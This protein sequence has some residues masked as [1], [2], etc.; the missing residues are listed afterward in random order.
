MILQE[1]IQTEANI[2]SRVRVT[3]SGY[4]I[5]RDRWEIAYNIE[6]IALISGTILSS[7]RRTVIIQNTQ[8]NGT[9]LTEWFSSFDGQDSFLEQSLAKAV[10]HSNLVVWVDET[11]N[12][13]SQPN[14]TDALLWQ[15]N[16]Q[17]WPGQRRYYP[18]IDPVVY[19]ILVPHLSLEIYPPLTVG[20]HAVSA[21][22][23]LPGDPPLVGLPAWQPWNGGT[24]PLYQVGQ[25]V[26]HNGS[27][28]RN[29]R[30]N[31]FNEPSTTNQGGWLKI[32]GTPYEWYAV[33]NEGYPLDFQVL[34]QGVLKNS[35]L[36][37]NFYDPTV[38]VAW[39]NV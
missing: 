23:T 9:A 39:I 20:L 24:G 22:Q 12:V 35:I 10:E 16:Q 11:D 7:Q 25:E 1:T 28:W 21:N 2:F 18:Q 14:A 19:D 6:R 27:N 37:N 36:N 4:N 13:L 17:L 34:Y 3:S 5:D 32:S 31:N 38:G 29:R 30:A 15:P 8:E 26:N 33:G